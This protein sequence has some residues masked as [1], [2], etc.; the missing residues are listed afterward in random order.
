MGNILVVKLSPDSPRVNQKISKSNLNT[1]P[2]DTTT[3]SPPKMSPNP[4]SAH[5]QPLANPI[6]H[7]KAIPW[8]S[9]LL[10]QKSILRIDIPDRTPLPSTES[11]L[12]RESLNTSNT[13]KA[14][15]TY[16]KYVKASKEE[17]EVRGEEKANPFL[18][19]GALVDLQSGVNGYA[20]TAHGG[21]YGVV[22][23]EVMGTAANMQASMYLLIPDPNLPRMSKP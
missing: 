14:C 9:Q 13:V 2:K 15:I 1:S 20:K 6:A 12:V 18:E 16:L 10:S 7:F 8:C 23:D 4:Q 19:V 17:M 5:N 22:L 11:A 3:I 21:F